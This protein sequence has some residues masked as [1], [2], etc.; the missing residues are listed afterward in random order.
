MSLIGDALS[1]SWPLRVLASVALLLV[2]GGFGSAAAGLS[3]E[4]RVRG[5]NQATIAESA[6][7]EARDPSRWRGLL[8]LGA[9]GVTLFL[10][11]VVLL[12]GIAT[13]LFWA[14]D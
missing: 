1:G 3:M 14:K 13:F 7:G 5:R 9:L 10:V 12:L 4:V 11:G 2:F 8:S 6:P